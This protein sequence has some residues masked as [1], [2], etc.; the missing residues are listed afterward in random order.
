MSESIKN[1][2]VIGRG[3]WATALVKILSHNQNV[4]IYWYVNDENAVNYITEFGRNPSYLTDV[5]IDLNKVKPVAD[6][7]VAFDHAEYLVLAV[8]SA[9]I[10]STLQVLKGKDWNNKKIVSG[11]KGLVTAKYLTVSQYLAA[12]FGAKT[13]NIAF[14]AGPCHSEEIALE[15]L[16]FLEIAVSNENHY[17]NFSV[18]FNNRYVKSRIIF[19]LEGAEYAAVLKN[20]YAVAC[21][22]FKGLDY[23]D[24]F[25]S[26]LIS[27]SMLEMELL[28]SKLLSVD[29]RMSRPAYLGDLLVTCYSQFSR[30]RT[31]GNMIGRGYSVASAQIEMKMIAEGY[32]G[33]KGIHTLSQE[34]KIDLPISNFVFEALYS[35]KKAKPLALELTEKMAI[36]NSF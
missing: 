3:S 16:S 27:Y 25:I 2:A 14:I 6:I 10:E 19:D 18:F 11:I 34:M 9:F 17:T 5:E 7:Q 12:Y 28:L 32:Y 20:I 1:I 30:N 8:P 13:E 31:L 4:Q 24:N 29:R 33:V 15:R 23:G 21:G 35:A 22:I 26:V 36:N